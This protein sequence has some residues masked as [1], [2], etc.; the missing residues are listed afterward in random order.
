MLNLISML[1]EIDL[2][3][4]DNKAIREVLDFVAN[5]L[6]KGNYLNKIDLVYELEYEVSELRRKRLNV[7]KNRDITIKELLD[8]GFNNSYLRINEE[9]FNLGYKW[10]DCK[11]ENFG[12]ESGDFGELNEQQLNCVVHF[13]SS[14]LDDDNC[15]C[16]NVEL[17]DK[18]DIKYFK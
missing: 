15:M 4:N 6:E 2:E 1:R 16:I 9:W 7:I 12:Y 14:E 3:K 18:E 8:L 10:F 13:I 5:E 11:K 17:K